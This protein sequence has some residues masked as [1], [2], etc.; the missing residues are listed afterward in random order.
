LLSEFEYFRPL[1]VPKS[2]DCVVFHGNLSYLPNV[3]AVLEFAK[4]IYPSVKR[5][6]ANVTFR[7]IGATPVN[8]I[9]EL[10][11][12]P[13][14]ELLA[15]LPDLRA[16]LSGAT[17]YVCPVRYGSGVKNKLLEAMAME[18]PIIAYPEAVIGIDCKSGR[19]LLIVDSA[20]KFVS[21][22]I[23]LLHDEKQRQSLGMAARKFVLDNFDW[24][25]RVRDFETLY[26][27]SMSGFEACHSRLSKNQPI[28]SK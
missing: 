26:E 9:R 11:V 16:A 15:D 21:C 7:I 2:T 17:V 3:A 24:T 10:A 23:E 8:D 18:L 1:S 14:F 28:A 6:R 22:V 19:E 12:P 5:S 13:D 20:E 25:S 4:Q 27:E